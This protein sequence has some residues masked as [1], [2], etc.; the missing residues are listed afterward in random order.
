MKTDANIFLSSGGCC[1]TAM[2]VSGP[3]KRPSNWTKPAATL[4]PIPKGPGN[5]TYPLVTSPFS[6]EEAGTPHTCHPSNTPAD[7]DVLSQK[8]PDD[9]DGGL[10]H[11]LAGGFRLLVSS[12]RALAGDLPKP[13]AVPMGVHARARCTG[14]SRTVP[15]QLAWAC[16]NPV[17]NSSLQL[18]SL[19]IT[20]IPESS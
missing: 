18:V 9:V 10:F 16:K 12:L 2:G 7:R 8:G 19:S 5:R 11:H 15:F 3:R 6:G 13:T 1:K 4:D 20:I 14:S 17:F